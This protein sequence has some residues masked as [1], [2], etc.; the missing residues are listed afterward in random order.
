M[1][2]NP[3]GKCA[4]CPMNEWGS[5]EG[6]RAKACRENKNLVVMLP[7]SILPVLVSLPV[8][9]IKPSKQYM[10]RL[11]QAAVAPWAVETVITL[12]SQNKGGQRW[13]TAKFV[14]GRTLDADEKA[15]AGD[16]SK[17][18]K[19]ALASSTYSAAD[20]IDS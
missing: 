17:T 3:T 7:G 16:Y 2:E 12:E 5:A 15:A 14:K 10:M 6:S 19:E 18:V 9:S 13:S 20:V 4:S 8:S 11:A 1:D